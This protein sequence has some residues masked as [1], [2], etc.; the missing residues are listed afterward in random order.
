LDQ[1]RGALRSA[2]QTVLQRIELGDLDGAR[3]RI[4]TLLNHATVGM[5]LNRPWDVVLTGRANVGKSSLINALLGYQ[6]C[7]VNERPGTT[8]DVLTASTACD[9]WPI[10]LAD[11]AGLRST[12]D[13]IEAEGVRR[14]RN[15]LASADAVVL[16]FD[17]SQAWTAEDDALFREW[18]RAIVVHN[19][20]DAGAAPRDS[21]PP[22]LA[23]CALDGR[24]V[25]KLMSQ[26]VQY[27]VPSP[28]PA[29]AAVPFNHRQ[30][31]A[32]RGALT[33]L[34]E[35]RPDRAGVI[36]RELQSAKRVQTS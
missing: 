24:G 27:L 22:G 20:S 3:N 17:V 7:I 14:A 5:H 23:T 13:A 2:L 34:D 9:G 26:L 31:T 4:T 30:L 11:T 19:K 6:R 25:G 18:P 28:P 1:L 21:R 36:L 16:V 10:R 35:G 33:E 29:G 15:R 8:R 12:R 32:L